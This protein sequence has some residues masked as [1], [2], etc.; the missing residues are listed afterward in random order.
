MGETQ[1][2][3]QGNFGYMSQTDKTNMPSDKL[4]SE[5]EQGSARK[6]R[7]DQVLADIRAGLRTKGFLEKY[8]LTM[9]EFERLLKKMIRK[10]I[11][12]IEEYTAW[13]SHRRTDAPT[14]APLLADIDLP[15]SGAAETKHGITTY[16]IKDPEKNDSWAL[17]LFSTQR[18]MMQGAAF[19]VDLHGKRYSFVVEE[20]LFRGPVDML[21]GVVGSRAGTKDKREEAIEFISEHG[22]AAYLESRAIDANLSASS[23]EE[24]KKARLVLLHCRNNTF[25][26]A[27][28][29]PAPAINLY[30]GSS[31]NNIKAR[32]AK[33]VDTS[34]LTL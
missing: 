30:V 8:G 6:V 15:S 24:P 22:W 12:S 21:P 28:H 10:G 19:K 16:V 23:A 11:L 29:T 5:S 26:A 20:M 33:S 2:Q 4:P 25:L 17:K 18:N 32:L 14:A 3:W 27:L 9:G 34:S 31:L 7:I 13:K 1:L